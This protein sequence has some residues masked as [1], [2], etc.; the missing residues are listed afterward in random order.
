MNQTPFPITPL[1]NY[2]QK[3]PKI[4]IRFREIPE[5]ILSYRV[6]DKNLV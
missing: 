5:K 2:F 6:E 3:F 4:F 1:L